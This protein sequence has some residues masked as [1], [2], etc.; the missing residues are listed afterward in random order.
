MVHCLCKQI[1]HILPSNAHQLPGSYTASYS[2]LQKILLCPAPICL[3]Y[4][5][6]ALLHVSSTWR[7]TKH[8]S[9]LLLAC[10]IL[11]QSIRIIP[12]SCWVPSPIL[13][14]LPSVAAAEKLSHFCLSSGPIVRVRCGPQ[15]ELLYPSSSNYPFTTHFAPLAS[16]K[17]P[18]TPPPPSSGG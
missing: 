2:I 3:L 7:C 17:S 12:I 4:P 8:V 10:D 18:A 11:C 6:D 15:H 1:K 16:N 5:H 14:L 13:A 9:L